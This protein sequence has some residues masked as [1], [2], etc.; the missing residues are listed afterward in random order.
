MTGEGRATAGRCLFVRETTPI[1]RGC[2]DAGWL[3]VRRRRSFVREHVTRIVQHK[4]EFSYI[5]A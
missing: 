3:L 4:S 2:Q 5:V 1:Q